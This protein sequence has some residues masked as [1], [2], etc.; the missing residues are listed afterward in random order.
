M[1]ERN[2]IEALAELQRERDAAR[3]KALR[4]FAALRENLAARS[5]PARIGDRAAEAALD[6]LET[7]KDVARENKVVVGVTIAALLGWVLRGPITRLLGTRL[8]KVS[9][10]WWPFA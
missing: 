7:A 1:N 10:K 6:T 3:A 9:A 5:I 2:P 4:N 8:P